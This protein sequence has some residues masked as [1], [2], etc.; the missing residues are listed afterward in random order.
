[1]S[2]PSARKLAPV[3][4]PRQLEVRRLRKRGLSYAEIGAML[5]ISPRTV[6]H[7][8]ERMRHRLGAGSNRAA[9]HA[10]VRAAS[11]PVRSDP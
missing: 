3:L 5:G 9:L 4:T 11:P 8:L 10:R 6:E 7:H 2:R 1:M